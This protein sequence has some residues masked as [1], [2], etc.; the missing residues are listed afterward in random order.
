MEVQFRC[1]VIGATGFVGGQIVRAALARG[2]AVRGVRRRSDAVGALA[3]V[4]EQVEWAQADLA[5]LAALV[6]AMQG[7][8]LVFHAGG[9]YPRREVDPWEAVRHGVL[10]MRNVF[11]AARVA[12]V[13]R[14]VY[15][16]SFVTV[17][18]PITPGQPANED[19]LPVP[20]LAR[21]PYAEV[22]WAMEQEALRATLDGLPVVVVVP[23][24]VFGPGE[25]KPAVSLQWRVATRRLRWGW[26]GMVSVVDG[27][28]LALG[29]LLAA[30]RG[31]PGRRYI[32]AGHYMSVGELLAAM[33]EAAGG[34]P[35]H[36][37][38]SPRLA[39]GGWL[40]RFAAPAAGLPHDLSAWQPLD[41][42][43]A[44]QELGLAEP[45]PFAETCRD[46]VDWLRAAGHLP[47]VSGEALTPKA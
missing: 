47:A 11:A 27:R 10:G 44:R 36:L 21:R 34:A 15:T 38:L 45:R 2:W 14:I 30:E 28:D 12:R 25:V 29:H 37:R 4:A 7:C 39:A 13:R 20:G 1:C 33:A 8:P 35:P 16:S 9:Y 3:D 22:K 17:G 24:P 23:A 41:A 40:G 6:V 43:R 26:N 32:I 5:D 31:K 46:S 19:S 18:P 42:A